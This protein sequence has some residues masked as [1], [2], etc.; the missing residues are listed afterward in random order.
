MRL[1]FAIT[2]FCWASVTNAETYP[3]YF[4]VYVW[5]GS[6]NSWIDIPQVSSM[7]VSIA[8]SKS[9]PDSA[10]SRLKQTNGW[11]EL[12]GFF[13]QEVMSSPIID[14]TSGLRII[15][16]SKNPEIKFLSA[17][18]DKTEFAST[19]P[20]GESN[21]YLS[22][23]EP[24]TVGESPY[25][26]QAGFIMSGFGVPAQQLKAKPIDQFTTEYLSAPIQTL[27]R[28]PGVGDC[29]SCDLIVFG[30]AIVTSD[31]NFHVFET[32]QRLDAMSGGGD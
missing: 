27:W 29:M 11:Y 17:L 23:L 19:V 20:P 5:D 31:G 13:S 2:L 10:K 24:G 3:E 22:T 16:K 26:Q 25:S 6:S 4:G 15:I 28:V 8:D 12:T 30:I 9:A 1:L 32:R 7:P 18:V 14:D 21:N